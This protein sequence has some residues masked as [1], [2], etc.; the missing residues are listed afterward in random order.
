M[1]SV[2]ADQIGGL[3]RLFDPVPAQ[4]AV[5]AAIILGKTDEFSTS[6]DLYT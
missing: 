4:E 1:R 6:L 5:H 2:R 3:K